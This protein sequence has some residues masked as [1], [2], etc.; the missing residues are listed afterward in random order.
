MEI[1]VLGKSGQLGTALR[2]TNPGFRVR[3]LGCEDID[4]A[5]LAHGEGHNPAREALAGVGCLVNCAARTDVDKQESDREAAE[6]V[7]HRGVERLGEL[8]DTRIVHVSTD[9]VF[10]SQAP[11]V[12]LTPQDETEPDT[13]YGATKLAGER[14]LV[15]RGNALIVRTAWLFS[16]DCLPSVKDF[17]STMV[18]RA[19]QGQASRVVA[20]QTGS[21]TFAFDLARGLWEAVDS[22][23]TGVVHAVG[24]G[25][26]TWFE[27][28]Q[29]AYQAAG[30]DP[31]LVTACTSE[32]YPQVA[33]RPPWSV[34]STRSWELAGFTPFPEWR[35]GVERA[36]AGRIQ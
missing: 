3:W 13:V 10:G 8:T 36:V 30:S 35:S 15:Q 24:N 25:Q 21:P 33:K 22:E 19:R 5:A 1:A 29:A 16:G 11:R 28:A 14:A 12:P 4:L 9:Y 20:D 17:V 2:L 34:L 23:A 32:E 6:D 31:G 7:N 26:A 18:A 27:V